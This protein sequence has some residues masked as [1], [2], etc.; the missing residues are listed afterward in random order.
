MNPIERIR[1]ATTS[2]GLSVP[3]AISMLRSR[4]TA[5]CCRSKAAV[6]ASEPPSA[7]VAYVGLAEVAYQRD[8]LDEARRHV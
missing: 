8:D 3:A 4:R 1:H 7:G 6:A 2:R 5:G